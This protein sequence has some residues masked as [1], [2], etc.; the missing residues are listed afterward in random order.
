MH[1]AFRIR[2]D[3][4]D[5]LTREPVGS[6]RNLVGTELAKLGL[7]LGKVPVRDPRSADEIPGYDE[8]GLPN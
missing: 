7:K 2:K 4:A 8:R 5:R 1:M 6:K 3:G